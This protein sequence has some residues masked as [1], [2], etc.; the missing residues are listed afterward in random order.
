MIEECASPGT[1]DGEDN[2]VAFRVSAAIKE[3]DC[4]S[5]CGR[6][7]ARE[8]HS[9]PEEHK[10]VIDDGVF[11]ASVV[12]QVAIGNSACAEQVPNHGKERGA[13]ERTRCAGQALNTKTAIQYTKK[14]SSATNTIMGKKIIEIVCR[15]A[16]DPSRTM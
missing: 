16:K 3:A 1:R 9:D 11:D 15:I 14:Q 10:A 6:D 4:A 13:Y 7:H 2:G 5:Q 8:E 12:N